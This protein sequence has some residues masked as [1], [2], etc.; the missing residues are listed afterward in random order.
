MSAWRKV[1]FK[2]ID[3]L[4]KRPGVY[5]VYIDRRL[6][7]VGQSS[8]VRSR[9]LGG[10]AFN[11]SRYSNSI[12]TPWGATSRD[13]FFK[14]R[15]SQAYGDWLAIEARLIRKLKPSFNRIGGRRLAHG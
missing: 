8:N 4:P 12:Q 14:V 6:V 7:Y 2:D 1:R 15:G 9:I 11:Y 10:H 3:S 5:A 13:V